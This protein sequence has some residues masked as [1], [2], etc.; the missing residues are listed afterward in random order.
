[1][2][3]KQASFLSFKDDCKKL[4]DGSFE[5]GPGVVCWVLLAC[6]A[7]GIIIDIS[8]TVNALT[9]KDTKLKQYVAIVLD[10]FVQAF[11]IFIIYRMCFL[12]NPWTGILIIC[13]LRSF[14]YSIKRY[15]IYGLV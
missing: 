8:Y 13:M 15:L 12:C 11:S 2:S 3:T 4:F 7:L 6:M 14:S 9:N 10:L 5:R 1:M